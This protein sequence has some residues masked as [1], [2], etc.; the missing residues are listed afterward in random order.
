MKLKETFSKIPQHYDKSRIGYPP[1]V[2]RDIIAYA[3]LRKTDPILEI[4]AGTGIATAPFARMGNP[5]VVNDLSRSL[6]GVAKNKL[7]KYR[8]IKYSIGQYENVRL[9]K[10]YFGLIYSAQA[11]HWI[12]P[13]ARFSLT[14][15][16]LKKGGVVAL[17]WNFSD[18]SKGVAKMAMRLHKKYFRGKDGK[19]NVIIKQ[20][21]RN[22]RFTDAIVKE[23]HRHLH[24]T[25]QEYIDMQTS[26]SWY[27][28]L[29]D[30]RKRLA[31]AEL[32]QGLQKFP[33][34]LPIPIKTRL[35]LARKK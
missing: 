18:Y 29:S 24:M 33:N 35:I 26:F 25:K 1:E 21:K 7:K 4:G 17:F 11:F 27:L 20:L 3:R 32:K 28:A 15:Q 31:L 19:A 8:K 13:G 2:F 34:R 14:L 6:L 10:N 5:L 9:P 30:A 22:E 12:K 16:L 23:Y